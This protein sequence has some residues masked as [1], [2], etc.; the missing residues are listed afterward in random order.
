M[1]TAIIILSAT[2]L[3]LA[4]SLGYCN[5]KRRKAEMSYHIERG[6][7]TALRAQNE[8]LVQQA[9]E[10]YSIVQQERIAHT[11]TAARLKEYEGKQQ[12]LGNINSKLE[13]KGGKRK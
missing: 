2:V 7:N 13:S 1:I 5:T 6:E 4:I 12:T 10:L 9:G 8:K 3:F 11:A